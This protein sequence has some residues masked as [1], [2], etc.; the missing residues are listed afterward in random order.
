MITAAVGRDGTSHLALFS[1]MITRFNVVCLYTGTAQVG[2]S[3]GASS[4]GWHSVR[5]SVA[6]PAMLTEVTRDFPQSLKA[7]K[8]SLPLPSTFCPSHYSPSSIIRRY[9]YSPTACGRVSAAGFVST[10]IFGS[11]SRGTLTTGSQKN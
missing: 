1:A 4:F 7:S 11:E 9:M 8:S 6:T 2:S 5:I 3:N 10:V